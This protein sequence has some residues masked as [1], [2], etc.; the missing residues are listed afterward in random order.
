MEFVV[1]FGFQSDRAEFFAGREA[2]GDGVR[3]ESGIV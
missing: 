3:F 1:G 2:E